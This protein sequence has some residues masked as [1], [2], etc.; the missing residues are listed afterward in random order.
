MLRYIYQHLSDMI[1]H[2][3]CFACIFAVTQNKQY[4]EPQKCVLMLPVHLSLFSFQ[5][6]KPKTLTL[7]LDGSSSC[8]L[9][10]P[11]FTLCTD[12]SNNGEDPAAEWGTRLLLRGG[13]WHRAAAAA[14]S[15]P[16]P[17]GRQAEVGCHICVFFSHIAL[18]TMTLK[19]TAKGEDA[20]RCTL[21]GWMHKAYRGSKE[22]MC[23]TFC[24]KT[25]CAHL[26]FHTKVHL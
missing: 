17:G 22:T 8:T 15:P 18:L 26:C 21:K 12:A 23:S 3:V 1:V 25:K 10:E 7:S 9:M 14:P 19:Q 20:T 6:P 16:R 4:P 2:C 13:E 11:V 5:V 24:M